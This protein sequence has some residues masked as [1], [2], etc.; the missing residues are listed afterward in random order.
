MLNLSA[1]YLSQKRLNEVLDRTKLPAGVRSYVLADPQNSGLERT[2][3]IGAYEDAVLDWLTAAKLP[4]LGEIVAKGRLSQG[5]FFTYMGAF[6]GKGISEAPGRFRQGLPL[7]KEPVLWTKLDSFREGLTLTVQAHPENYT[8]SSASVEMSGKKRLFLVARLTECETDELRAQAYIVGHLHD[9]PRKGTPNVDL[10]GRLPWQMEVFPVQISNFS[11]CGS[12][13]APTAAE[14]KKILTIPEAEVKAAFAAIIGEPY[15]SKDWGGEKSDLVST[16]VRL[17]GQPVSTAF[18]FKG[19]A[20]PKPLTVADLGKNGDQISRLFSEPSDFVILQHCYAVTSAVR[21]H[22]R[23]FA[24]RI[25]Q[26]R[27]FCIIDGA[28]AIRI[29]RAYE[30]LG[31]SRKTTQDKLQSRGVL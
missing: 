21:D 1:L 3:V 31:F 10:F 28:D 5:V 4:T 23:A 2:V 16:Q 25:G 17:E 13:N 29:F 30:K 12:E 8:S 15:V 7:K 22:M 27:P 9:E 6:N 20:K 19:P 14:L 11:A 24:T 26:L 18:A